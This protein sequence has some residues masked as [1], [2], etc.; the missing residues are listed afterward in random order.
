MRRKI[1]AQNLGS[2]KLLFFPYHIPSL[3]LTL[4]KYRYPNPDPHPKMKEVPKVNSGS[5]FY[6]RTVRAE[7]TFISNIVS[8]IGVRRRLETV[9]ENSSKFRDRRKHLSPPTITPTLTLTLLKYPYPNLNL[10]LIQKLNLSVKL[11]S[12]SDFRGLN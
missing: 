10:T 6:R 12:Y 4:L 9:T 2:L 3:T 5:L 1:E 7:I 11:D 8:P